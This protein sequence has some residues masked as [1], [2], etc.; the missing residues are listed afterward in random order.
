M[1]RKYR[2]VNRFAHCV[3]HDGEQE[4][5]NGQAL[6][7]TQMDALTQ[8]GIPI[9]TNNV[10]IEYETGSE[11]LDFEPPLEFRRGVD[12][13]DVFEAHQDVKNRF[14]R[15]RDEGRYKPEVKPEGTI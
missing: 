2:M 10:G 8:Q 14:R 15:F 9:S 12:I 3:R 5:V 1:P 13:G 11:Q 4:V 7:P 6:T